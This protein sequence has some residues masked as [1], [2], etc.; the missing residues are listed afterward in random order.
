MIAEG[1]YPYVNGGVSSWIHALIQSMPEHEFIIYAIGAEEG[2]QGNFKYQLPENVIEVHEIFLDTNLFEEGRWG[3]RYHLKEEQ[4]EALKSLILGHLDVEWG[5]LF[6]LILTPKLKPNDFLM[7]RDF[8]D[9]LHDLCLQNFS[10]LPF[11]DLF[12]TVRSMLL[13]LFQIVQQPMP[14]ADLYHSVSTGYAGVLGSLGKWLYQKPYLLTE[15]GIYT[16]E[17]EEEI[18]KADWVKG[19]YKD[20]W[21]HYFYSLSYCSYHSANQVITLFNGNKQ[22]EMELGC[23]EKKIRIIPNGINADRFRNLLRKPMDE[24]SIWIGAIVRV[25]PVKDIKTMLQS[26]NLVKREIPHS[27]F[28]IMGPYDEDLEY[29][30]ECLQMIEAL[31]LE[32]VIFTGQVD[33][34]AYI[35]QMDLLVLTSISEGQPLAVLE[36]MAAGIPFV[37]TDVGSCKELL[38]GV[39]DGIGKAGIVVSVMDYEKIANSI[40]FLCKN[41]GKRLEMGL[42]GEKRVGRLYRVSDQVEHYKNLYQTIGEQIVWQA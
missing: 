13:P 22:I 40:I 6:S 1:S 36:G 11:T 28:Y 15:H 42:N 37:S 14:E 39:D 23:P 21:I 29:Y 8:F 33:L 9:L 27:K 12:W 5:Y 20:L 10:R 38:Y 3:Q 24:S 19:D 41:E 35:G 34:T 30:M 25:V 16:R 32:D 31:E 18:I 26:F 17:R 4:K 7:S 2:Q